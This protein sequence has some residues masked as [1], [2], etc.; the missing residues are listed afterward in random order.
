MEVRIAQDVIPIAEFKARAKYWLRKALASGH[1]IVITQ[2][3]KPAGVLLSPA[4]FDQLN[5][6]QRFLESVASGLADADAGRVMTTS[7]LKKRLAA[8]RKARARKQR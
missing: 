3:G 7:E 5:E 6:R 8:R 1:P 2:N 4:E